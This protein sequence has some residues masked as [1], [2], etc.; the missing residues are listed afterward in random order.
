M[1]VGIGLASCGILVSRRR[2]KGRGGPALI[3]NDVH[4]FITHLHDDRHV[5]V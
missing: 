4:Q 5:G 3:L 2:A 1:R